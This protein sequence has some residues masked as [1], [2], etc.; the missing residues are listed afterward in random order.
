MGV[1]TAKDLADYFHIGGYLDRGADPNTSRAPAL[2]ADLVDDGRLVPVTVEG[3]RDP[4]FVL[5]CDA[6]YRRRSTRVHC[7]RRSTR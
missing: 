2:I 4:A 6:R 3:W 5:R 7:C 1:A